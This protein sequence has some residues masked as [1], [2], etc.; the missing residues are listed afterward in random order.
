M[1]IGNRCLQS[2]STACTITLR[3]K[4]SAGPSASEDKQG[5]NFCL[6]RI[7]QIM[8]KIICFF[9]LSISFYIE[10]LEQDLELPLKIRCRKSIPTLRKAVHLTE[11]SVS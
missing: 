3:L 11:I 10:D 2:S 9:Y 1:S 7:N 6:N 4:V 5:R 8:L